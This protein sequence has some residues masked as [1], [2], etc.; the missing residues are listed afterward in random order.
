MLFTKNAGSHSIFGE[1]CKQPLLTSKIYLIHKI[2]T[3][4]LSTRSQSYINVSRTMKLTERL[5]VPGS[6]SPGSH[7]LSPPPKFLIHS[8]SPLGQRRAVTVVERP[9]SGAWVAQTQT[10]GCGRGREPDLPGSGFPCGLAGGGAPRV[11]A[12]RQSGAGCSAVIHINSVKLSRESSD[13][14]PILERF[15]SGDAQTH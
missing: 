2:G 8:A 15:F 6:R 1:K 5:N 7:S 14:I 4:S 10:A 3:C 9:L 13:P 11:H 12:R